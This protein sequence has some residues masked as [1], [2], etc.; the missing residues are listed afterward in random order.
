VSGSR[1]ERFSAQVDANIFCVSKLEKIPALFAEGT[2]ALKSPLE[3]AVT[4]NDVR[5]LDKALVAL[6]AVAAAPKNV[7]G[8]EA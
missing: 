5:A 4:P 8:V 1:E 7:G 6:S 2:K 3:S